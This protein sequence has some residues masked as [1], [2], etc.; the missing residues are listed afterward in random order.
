ML[1]DNIPAPTAYHVGA[2]LELRQ[3]RIP[4]REHWS[5]AAATTPTELVRPLQRGLPR[6][7]RPAR[8]DPPDYPG[9]RDSA[10]NPF[11]GPDSDRCNVD[12]IVAVGSKC[13]ETYAWGLRN[14]FRV[15]FDA[16]AAGTRFFIN[17]IGEI[18]WEE[19]DLDRPAPTTAG[20]FAR[21]TARRGPRPTAARLR[22][23][24]TNPIYDYIHDYNP[25]G[26]MAITGGAF[27]PNGVWPS[28]FDGRYLYADLDL[29]QDLQARSRSGQQLHL[30]RCSAAAS[31]T[32]ASFP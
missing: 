20:T 14:P 7:E 15:A 28:A 4:V 29:R 24:M 18:T 6:P 11:Q 23:G 1:I 27:V 13:Q 2:D 21:V 16:N 22:P 10:D 8:Q 31:A 3:G 12:R 25:G 5:T 30:D 17:D 19:I 26:C 32:T 9:R